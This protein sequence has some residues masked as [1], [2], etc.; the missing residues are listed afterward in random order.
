MTLDTFKNLYIAEL[1]DLYSAELQLTVGLP[2]LVEAVQ[3]EDLK[4]AFRHHLKE[5]QEHVRRLQDIFDDLEVA[6]GGETC[7]AMQGLIDEAHEVI[8]SYGDRDV[9]DVAL[10]GCAQKIEHYEIAGY[11]TT[12]TFARHL[13]LDEQAELLDRTL[14]EEGAAD[15]KLTSLAEGGWFTSG[16]NKEA[17]QH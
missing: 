8:E 5:T 15:H 9:K 13:G 10:I 1:Q 14:G 16:I 11:G 2:Q 6:P 3:H 4:R 17:A 12:R 7:E